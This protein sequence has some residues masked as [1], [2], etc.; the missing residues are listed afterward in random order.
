MALLTLTVNNLSPALD[1]KS[2]EAAFIA[3]ALQ[4]AA[5]NI[6]GAGGL[7]TSGNIIADGGVNVGSWTLTNQASQP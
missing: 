1:K 6:Q 5:T 4:I 3:R 2:S 7:Q